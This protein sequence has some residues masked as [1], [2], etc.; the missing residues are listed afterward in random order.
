MKKLVVVSLLALAIGACTNSSSVL[1]ESAG[2]VQE[3]RTELGPSREFNHFASGRDLYTEI[4]GNPF[5]MEDGEFQQQITG[6][7]NARNSLTPTNFTVKPG[8]NAD[9]GYRAVVV[10]N[11]ASHYGGPSLCRGPA[12]LQTAAQQGSRIKIDMAFCNGR[13]ELHS[14]RGTLPMTASPKDPDF[15]NSLALTLALAQPTDES[16]GN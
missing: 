6:I 10:F 15:E 8:P 16:S 11:A 12:S 7:F 9:P 2:S 1:L 13:D 4:H 3:S 14:V 5:A